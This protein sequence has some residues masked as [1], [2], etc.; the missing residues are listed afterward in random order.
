MHHHLNRLLAGYLGL[1]LLN[2]AC[3]PKISAFKI[4]PRRICAGDTVSITFKTRGQARLLAVRRG[5]TVADT[6]TYIIVAES[7]GKPAYRMADV[8]PFPAICRTTAA[9]SRNSSI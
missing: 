3:G 2:G 7:H 1:P 4:E 8:V 5:G 9:A 6:T